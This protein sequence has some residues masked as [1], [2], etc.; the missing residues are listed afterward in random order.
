[1]LRRRWFQ[2]CGESDL[3]ITSTLAQIRSFFALEHI[4]KTTKVR[5]KPCR[6]LQTALVTASAFT[7]V[8]S[9]LRI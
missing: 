4:H 7:G 3:G 9:V 2:L 5:L 1:M 8:C 6:R